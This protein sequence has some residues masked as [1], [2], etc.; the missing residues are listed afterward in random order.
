[1]SY[2]EVE[3]LAASDVAG[4]MLSHDEIDAAFANYGE[5]AVPALNQRVKDLAEKLLTMAQNGEKKGAR[6]L[7]NASEQVQIVLAVK[8]LRILQR[9]DTLVCV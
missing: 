7:M 8:K 9:S 3:V 6:K 4:N 2:S 5:M 1:M